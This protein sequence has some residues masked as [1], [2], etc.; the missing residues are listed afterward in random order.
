MLP[1]HSWMKPVLV[2]LGSLNVL[3]GV[4]MIAFYHESCKLL[5]LPKPHPLWLFQLTGGFALLLGIG[6]LLASRNPVRLRSVLVVGFL[7]HFVASVWMV[8]AVALGTLKLEFLVAVVATA[9]IYLTPL[10]V[11]I[12]RLF[13]LESA[14]KVLSPAPWPKT[15]WVLM[16]IAVAFPSSWAVAHA[17]N[18]IGARRELHNRPT[19]WTPLAANLPKSVG[20]EFP[21]AMVDA[22]PQ[23]R[24]VDP[25]FIAEI[26]DGSRRM[27]VLERRG[28]AKA[29]P[30]KISPSPL[31]GRGTGGEGRTLLDD[32]PQTSI[33]EAPTIFAD[34]TDRVLN[35]PEKAED[36]L[37]GWAFH[38]EYA[39]A[40]SPHWGEV[41]VRYTSM[42]GGYRSNRLS[43]FKLASNGSAID[44]ASEQVLIEMP[45]R[46]VVHKGGAV[47]FGPDG[48]LYTTFGT[49]ARHFPH[50]HAQRID[51]G[52][53]AGV[54]RIDPDCRGGK[55][56][57]APPRA[58]E[59][60]KTAGYF[61]PNDNPFV[62]Q[63]NVLEE[64]YSLGL[65]NPWRMSIDKQTGLVWVGDV[66]DRRCEEINICT[67]GSNHQFDY[68]EGTLLSRDYEPKAPA[69][70][71]QIIGHEASP[72]YEY[73]RDSV[74]RCVI[75]GY[76]YRGK[77]FP[78]LVGKYIYSDLCGRVCAITVD[79][80]NKLVD[81]QTI[82]V[83]RD[84]GHGV[85][86]L[87]EDADGEL[88][89]V[90]ICDLSAGGGRIY[91][92]E[93]GGHRPDQMLPETLSA[94][95]LFVDMKS[96]RPNPALVDFDVN[97]PL[98]SD[99][100][101][102]RRWI[103]LVSHEKIQGELNGKWQF[104]AGTIFVKH[105]DLPL[106]ESR[107]R[108]SG[109]GSQ[110]AENT[111][112]FSPGPQA[113]TSRRLETRILVC[114][115]HGGV[116]GAS[117]RWNADETEARLVNFSETE[118]IEYIDTYGEKQTQTWLYPGRFDCLACHNDH[119]GGVLGFTARQLNRDVYNHG[120]KENQLVKFALA[121]MFEFDCQP[122]DT[123][124]VVT[125][126]ALDD[127]S[128]SVENR[129]RSYLDSNCSHCHQPG[130]RFGG[131]DARFATPVDY[132]K[133][134][135]GVAFNHRGDNP[136]SRIVRPGDLDFSFLYVRLSSNDRF[137]R[138]PPLGRSVVHHDAVKLLSAWIKSLPPLPEDQKLSPATEGEGNEYVGSATNKSKQR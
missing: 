101:E 52:L 95:G 136:R 29:I 25:T 91:R 62:G 49:D 10:A 70:P 90:W 93:R 43:R 50:K 86:S 22:Y 37:L 105:F 102:K 12:R 23:L 55:I 76:V 68:M 87:G 24:F 7:L 41:F 17:V 103:G 72:L 54:L 83:V 110:H 94:T 125:L 84:P 57:H 15:V 133:I 78:E 35:V 19:K 13:G 27:I 36:G 96:L 18:D 112:S 34:L 79:E 116:F 98:W 85:S 134:V 114:D 53:W 56:S 33:D 118:D 42:A 1:L 39:E 122:A 69:K 11:M 77:K 66:G 48:F 3:L 80:S 31:S 65:R 45:E 73:E 99:R 97:M 21:Y 44:P 46:T 115:D 20:E 88:Y 104:P 30:K 107:G 16:L 128:A 47:A 109:V 82:A 108:E 71:E 106:D 2:V 8:R 74:N 127:E 137:M 130:G 121:G 60:G 132:Q 64:F 117:Y 131:W 26:P 28:L 100:A 67:P 124:R 129:V 6:Y 119:A 123:Q 4:V 61:V 32:P 14:S 92:F 81:H 59:V 58:P 120:L 40:N 38:P 9:I 63:P 138:M 51:Y 135:D 111:T 75:G 89:V 5:G 113:G 126:A